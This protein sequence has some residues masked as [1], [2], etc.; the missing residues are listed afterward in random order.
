MIRGAYTP[1]LRVQTEPFER[2]WKVYIPPGKYSHVLVYDGPLLSHPLG[3]APSTFTKCIYIYI[4]WGKPGIA[5]YY[6]AITV[7]FITYNESS[8]Q[9]YF[10][11]KKSKLLQTSK[12]WTWTFLNT[13]CVNGVFIRCH[14]SELEGLN[15]IKKHTRA[16]TLIYYLPG[17]CIYIHTYNIYIYNIIKTYT[18]YVIYFYT[19]IFL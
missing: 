18:L 12:I 3:V 4:K 2:C 14:L 7:W 17:I 1:S 16:L 6:I 8:K 5:I 10:M 15:L 19:H 11:H 13:W 9:F